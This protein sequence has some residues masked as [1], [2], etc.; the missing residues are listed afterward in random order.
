MKKGSIVLPPATEPASDDL[1]AKVIDWCLSHRCHRI[2]LC[3][4]MERGSTLPDA[5]RV[6]E[7][8]LQLQEEADMRIT[9]FKNDQKE[10]R[11]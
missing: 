10:Q 8:Y 11:E 3:M 9:S 5:D 1:I 4:M 2:L 7:L 6:E